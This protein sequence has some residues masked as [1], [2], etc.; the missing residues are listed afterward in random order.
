MKHEKNTKELDKL[1]KAFKNAERKVG[2]AFQSSKTDAELQINVDRQ[3]KINEYS[4]MQSAKEWA[5]K[6]LPKAF[7][8]GYK[9]VDLNS[10]V[11][12]T[13]IF[14]MSQSIL[15]FVEIG[16]KVHESMQQYKDGINQKLQELMKQDYVTIETVKK[17]ILESVGKA[18]SIQYQNGAKV[19]MSKYAEMLARTSRIETAN[20]GIIARC[21]DIK[22][23]LVRYMALPNC[24][25]RCQRFNNKVFSISGMDK[26]FPYLYGENGPFKGGY[27]ITHPN[28]RCEILPFVEELYKN[29]IN[30]I[31][32]ESNHFTNYTKD[33]KLFDEYNKQQAY[34][35][36]RNAELVEYVRLKEQ[37]GKEFPYKR[38]GDFRRARTLNSGTYRELKK[39]TKQH[40]FNGGL[41]EHIDI[42]TQL[43][44]KLAEY[45]NFL[46]EKEI[47]YSFTIQ[48]NGDVYRY[49]GDNGS[50]QSDE[51]KI[52][53]D[54]AINIHNH[55]SSHDNGFSK[56]DFK[57]MQKHQGATYI[58]FA[59]SN[60]YTA[61][62]LKDISN[63]N[64]NQIRLEAQSNITLQ[65]AMSADGFDEYDIV[66]QFLKKE[67]YIDYDKFRS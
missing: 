19:P 43:S 41:F 1:L 30:Q 17:T 28:C 44:D 55:P 48:R 67:G 65:E 31:I 8:K 25:P 15:P 3:A 26:R 46:K 64:Y 57:Y 66:Y 49:V 35:R 16:Q 32:K 33:D 45:Q 36:Q 11:P 14:D 52:D 21:R 23:D 34:N 47:E 56:E 5:E 39:R 58:L 22:H 51:D 38:L 4:L 60:T 37:L 2:E 10:A 24:C 9:S 27:N 6:E 54:G 12:T 20:G 7:E 63:L 40:E 42:N 50:V 61:T 18:P 62:I 59:K 53:F 13:A 29:E